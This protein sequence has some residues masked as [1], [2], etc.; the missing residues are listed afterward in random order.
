MNVNPPAIRYKGDR[1]KSIS[2]KSQALQFYLF[3][4]Q[5]LKSQNIATLN[6]DIVLS[7]GSVI[8]ANLRK[9]GIYNNIFGNIS[10][11]THAFG[12]VSE[13]HRLVFSLVDNAGHWEY[14]EDDDTA[15]EY[16]TIL[17]FIKGNKIIGYYPNYSSTDAA[18]SLAI[19]GRKC[20]YGKD[21]AIN[22]AFAKYNLSDDTEYL[23]ITNGSIAGLFKNL[24]TQYL[25]KTGLS[26]IHNN[27]EYVF[28][29]QPGGFDIGGDYLVKY[30]GQGM[31]I[32]HYNKKEI[33]FINGNVNSDIQYYV[34]GLGNGDV[35]APYYFQ[36][37]Y[38][39]NLV[40]LIDL[41]LIPANENSI[42]GTCEIVANS[43][44]SLPQKVPVSYI[45]YHEVTYAANR[46]RFTND[47]KYI[48]DSKFI[49]ANVYK[50][51][52][53]LY[54]RV[55]KIAYY[56]LAGGFYTLG[57]EVFLTLLFLTEQNYIHFNGTPP[58]I[59]FYNR[60]K[61]S[62]LSEIDYISY[63]T[64]VGVREEYLGF[65]KKTNTYVDTYVNPD[66]N[67]T[68]TNSVTETISSVKVNLRTQAVTNTVLKITTFTEDSIIVGGTETTIIKSGSESILECYYADYIN[69][70]Y[71]L[72]KM[73]ITSDTIAGSLGSTEYKVLLL[74]V[75]LKLL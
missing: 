55:V 12:G 24:P 7:D 68:Y 33:I 40:S 57:N 22:I 53:G 30:C 2:L 35:I 27:N 21:T 9:D 63:E 69:D 32:S 59:N 37:G 54:N 23:N 29:F 39:I 16:L 13:K 20:S 48:P 42:K 26:L 25:Y 43:N 73:K 51:G 14:L 71:V 17:P 74:K 34:F 11:E 62:I 61:S 31:G 64:S 41:K 60:D 6:R 19:S 3:L 36:Y 65:I 72:G 52:P 66:I 10:I 70:V 28:E 58:A 46:L 75:E 15:S 1:D 18:L 4:S 5:Q 50:A 38:L 56:Q 44:L 67:N 8:S 49:Y 45:A 47:P